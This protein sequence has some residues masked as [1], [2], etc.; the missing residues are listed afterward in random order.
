MSFIF[1]QA[2]HG[3]TRELINF[4][5]N[6]GKWALE[7]DAVQDFLTD[8]AVESAKYYYDYYSKYY[9]SSTQ[10]KFFI[11]LEDSD[12]TI[13][14][15]QDFIKRGAVVEYALLAYSLNRNPKPDIVRFLIKQGAYVNIHDH[16]G[17]TPIMLMDNLEC[18]K[19]LLSSGA[20]IK[21]K[22]Q[23]G[24]NALTMAL[25]RASSEYISV[26]NG[27]GSSQSV[28]RFLGQIYREQNPCKR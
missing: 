10:Q 26:K 21:A 12:I 1:V 3:F 15:I 19:L 24:G 13:V 4:A 5:I 27:L 14:A 7:Q 2:A 28:R 16:R 22:S 17:M 18:L 8:L 9:N 6:L 23:T 11:D 25:S 20:D